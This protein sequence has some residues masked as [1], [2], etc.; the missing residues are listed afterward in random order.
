[1]MLAPATVSAQANDRA[2]ARR[3][4]EAGNLAHRAGQYAVAAR[5]F[6][7]AYLRAP[8]PEITFSAAQ[9]HRLAYYQEQ[10]RNAATLGRALELYRRYLNE[11]PHGK[12]RAHATMHIEAI[13]GVLKPVAPPEP[14]SP[15]A[16]EEG[17]R[18]GTATS[19]LGTEL[20]V[21]SKAPG[22]RGRI[23]GSVFYDVP[24]SL[25]VAPG[26]RRVTVE[27]P[28]HRPSTVEWLAL[29]SR[30]VVAQVDPE[31]MPARLRVLAPD[32]AE[33]WANER[34]LGTAPLAQPIDLPPGDYQVRVRLRG[35]LPLNRREHVA[36]GETAT[37]DARE[38]DVT[39]QRV[40]SYWL[41]GGAA[42]LTAAG[43]TTTVLALGAQS[44]VERYDE[45]RKTSA[46]TSA[47]L[48]DRNADLEARND[49]RTASYVLFG[50]A[51][52]VGATG[53]F[54]WWLDTPSAETRVSGLRPLVGRDMLG[55]GWVGGN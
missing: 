48:A 36:R 28:G 3:Y 19:P 34:S 54:L 41:L 6:E 18:G 30:L 45:S 53:A 1:M 37:V 50:S 43:V 21:T 29:E 46:K 35:R 39:D 42:A 33:I 14:A 5:A 13:E 26:K 16:G 12:R 15:P 2:E 32:G 40:A 8:L 9:A 27:A 38:L 51:L 49:L 55:V 7:E 44:R 22:A 25:A 52:A 10:P 23:D 24:F 4:F 47:D 11:A 20:L 31:P 17:E